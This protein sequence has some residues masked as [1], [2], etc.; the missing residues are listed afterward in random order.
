MPIELG[1]PKYFKYS[2]LEGGEQL[3]AKGEFVG[4]TEG[5]FGNQY[6]FREIESGA[7]VVLNKAG[8][9][10]WRIENGHMVEG[11]VFDIYF[12][13]KELIESG[14]YAGKEANQFKILKYRD[15]EL[16]TEFQKSAGPPEGKVNDTPVASASTPENEA[17]DDLE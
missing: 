8:A 7:H 14:D 13:G 12:E 11:E 4:V 9:F 6:N 10:E 15:S 1:V 16:P 3:V 17:M 2:E 5:K